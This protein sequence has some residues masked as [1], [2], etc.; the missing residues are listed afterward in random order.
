MESGVGGGS[1]IE[2]VVVFPIAL[3]KKKEH[4]KIEKNPWKFWHIFA[5]AVMLQLL[6]LAEVGP[7][8]CIA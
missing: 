8:S 6:S 1:L 2:N 5:V 7:Q 4:W 3:G